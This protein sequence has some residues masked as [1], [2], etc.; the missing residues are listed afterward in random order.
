MPSPAERLGRPARGPR[1]P[2]RGAPA[3]RGSG[4]RPRSGRGP[5]HRCG[6]PA[7][8]SASGGS[9]SAHGSLAACSASSMIAWITGWKDR[10]PNVT[11]SSITVSGSSRASLSTISTPSAVPAT[12]RSSSDFSCCSAVGLSTRRPS[13]RP[14]RAAPTGPKNGMPE[15]VSAAE[16]PTSATMSGSFSRSWPSTVATICTSLRKPAGNSGRIGR[17]ISRLTSVSFSEAGPRA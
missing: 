13:I 7:A 8:R 9:G 10:W 14:T 17:S 12:T 11:A 2:R 5:V 3:S 1:R 6:R 15:S 4:R 16:Q